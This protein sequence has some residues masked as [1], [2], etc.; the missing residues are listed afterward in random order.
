MK[1]L[2]RM[3]G[4]LL[5]LYGKVQTED[6]ILKDAL[7]NFNLPRVVTDDKSI[8]DTMCEDLFPT[9]KCFYTPDKEMLETSRKVILDPKYI[10]E[11]DLKYRDENDFI[12]K[13]TQIAEILEV[14]H[15]M[16]VIGPAGSGKSAVIKTLVATL[17]M[18]GQPTRAE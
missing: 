17:N 9:L 13:I 5:R 16:F 7:L 2:L 8:F 12:T 10:K 3:A 11:F 6:T 18:M 14:R 1:S 15:C 4:K